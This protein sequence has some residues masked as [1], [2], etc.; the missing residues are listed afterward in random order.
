MIRGGRIV[1]NESLAELQA[2]A[3]HEVTIRWRELPAAEVEP[4]PFLILSERDGLTWHGRIAGPLEPF[5][6]WLAGR[7]IEDLHIGRP[8]LETLFRHYYA[9]QV[10]P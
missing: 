3:G 4:P 7:P 6:A 10:A 8:D 2:K 9:P 1:A 5:V